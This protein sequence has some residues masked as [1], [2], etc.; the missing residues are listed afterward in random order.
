MENKNQP[1]NQNPDHNNQGANPASSSGNNPTIANFEQAKRKVKELDTEMTFLE[2][3]LALI[4]K[5]EFKKRDHGEVSKI[6]QKLSDLTQERFSLFD[7]F[8]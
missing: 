5:Q 4:L 1:I 6:Q 8:Y 7:K 2:N 3:A